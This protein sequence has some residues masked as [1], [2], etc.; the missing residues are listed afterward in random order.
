VAGIIFRGV[1]PSIT[2][3]NMRSV[4]AWLF[5]GSGIMVLWL[6]FGLGATPSGNFAIADHWRWMTVPMWAE[7]TFE[8]FTTCIVAYLL[9][10]MGL[11]NR[12]MAERVVFL[13]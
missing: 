2:K 13:A 1:R 4:P 10:K 7:V 11:S 6:F 8:V 5:Y 12:A 3:Q 9:V